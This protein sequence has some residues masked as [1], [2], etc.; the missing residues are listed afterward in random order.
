MGLHD[1]SC[2]ICIGQWMFHSSP[3]GFYAS[4]LERFTKIPDVPEHD[5]G[6][7]MRSPTAVPD[8]V[9]PVNHQ[10]AYA[11]LSKLEKEKARNFCCTLARHVSSQ[12]SPIRNAV[13]FYA[14]A[15]QRYQSQQ[16][17]LNEHVDS[18]TTNEPEQQVPEFVLP[19]NKLS[20]FQALSPAQ[21]EAAREHCLEAAKQADTIRNPKIF[22]GNTLRRYL[23]NSSSKDDEIATDSSSSNDN[24][25]E[26]VPEFIFSI[27]QRAAFDGLSLIRQEAAKTYCLDAARA[28]IQSGKPIRN[29]LYFYTAAFNRFLTETTSVAAVAQSTSATTNAI[30]KQNPNNTLHVASSLQEAARQ[31]RP[32][33]G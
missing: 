5:A 27:S 6:K 32:K 7:S 13:A 24:K 4:V 28:Q 21:Q 2:T 14:K 18:P 10:G 3:K 31:G 8:F 26:S 22:Y 11:R 16:R 9:L 17:T 29:R 20:L 1:D 12:G 30:P 25:F 23:N 33:S 19:G 15:F